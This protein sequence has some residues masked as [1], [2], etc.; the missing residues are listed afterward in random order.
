MSKV[1]IGLDEWSEAET[2]F[3]SAKEIIGLLSHELHLEE[4]KQYSDVAHA[5]ERLI[6]SGLNWI[7]SGRYPNGH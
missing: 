2:D 1:R 5:V 3:N 6:E 4:H 7:E